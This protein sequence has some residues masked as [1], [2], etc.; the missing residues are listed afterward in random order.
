[1]SMKPASLMPSSHSQPPAHSVLGVACLGGLHGEVPNH[2]RQHGVRI[3]RCRA[4]DRADE[5]PLLIY[6][7][8]MQSFPWPAS[9][10][11]AFARMVSERLGGVPG[12]TTDV[13][14]IDPAVATQASFLVDVQWRGDIGVLCEV[15]DSI[16]A[17]RVMDDDGEDVSIEAALRYIE[18]RA[19][20]T[21]RKGAW[22]YAVG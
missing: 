14:R 22:R 12:V 13:R 2:R 10:G 11:E 3:W 1:V 5:E 21:S 4:V 19:A 8:S 7:A 9:S 6:S 20:G 18:A 17:V 15:A 16:D